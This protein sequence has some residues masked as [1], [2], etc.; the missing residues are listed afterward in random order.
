MVQKK[1]RRLYIKSKKQKKKLK[2]L[3]KNLKYTMVV[4]N[5]ITLN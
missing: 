4:Q 5:L 1:S 2:N 3:K